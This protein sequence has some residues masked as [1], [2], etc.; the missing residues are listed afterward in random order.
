[1]KVK[2]L[3]EVRSYG[4]PLAST[5]GDEFHQGLSRIHRADK[6][7]A[8]QHRGKVR[9]AEEQAKWLLEKAMKAA[10]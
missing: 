8:N 1:M 4:I 9:N 10:A 5:M 2:F 3:A 7:R 6:Q